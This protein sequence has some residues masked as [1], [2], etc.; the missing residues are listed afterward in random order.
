[1]LGIIGGRV[2]DP[3]NA[4]AGEIGDIWVKDGRIVAAEEIDREHAEIVDAAGLVVMAGGVDIHAHIVGGEVN[5]GRKLRPEDHRGHERTHSAALRAGAGGTVPSTYATGQLYS[6]LGYTTVMQASTAPLMARH[7]HEELEDTPNLDNG[8]FM[9]M[10]NN[11]FVMQSIADKQFDRARDYVAWLLRA[12]EGYAIKIVN[13]G[14]VENWK[15][16]SNVSEL[17]DEVI[18]YGVTPRQIMET[19][20]TIADDLELPHAVHIHG[21]N[22]GRHTSARTSI[23]T[24]KALDGH[25]AHLCHLQ[26]LSYGAGKGH[27]H[28]SEAVAVAQAVNA[29]PKLTVDVGQV[30]FG[31]ATTMTCDGPLQH[32]LHNTAGGRWMN[33]DVEG[34]SGGGIVPIV[35]APGNP[36]NATMWVTGLELYLLI[37]DPW[38]V[39]LTTDHPNAGTFS[40][41]PQIIRLLMD[42]GYREEMLASVHSRARNGAVLAELDREYSLS[43]IAVITRA[44]PARALGLKD[45][46]HLGVGADAD[47]AVY[48]E[49][50]DKEAMFA[51]PRYVY[52]GGELVAR[53]GVVLKQV[54]GRTFSVAPDYDPRIEDDMRAHFKAAYTVSYDNYAMLADDASCTETVACG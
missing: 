26:F 47:I 43:D 38:K 34:E 31:R 6:E 19:L 39:F 54:S 32:N 29:S 9:V 52:K 41:Y 53:D 1:M 11:H 2:Y 28:K 23:E 42:R 37:D 50:D 48:Q 46:G 8:A 36:I 45:K 24:I 7:T 17:D 25:R 16:G 20:A 13:P 4:K 51:R 27:V 18:G 44:G 3:Q 30:V 14:G 15:W 5:A 35:Y 33:D 49:Q 10:G 40:N 12:S 22:L 21:I